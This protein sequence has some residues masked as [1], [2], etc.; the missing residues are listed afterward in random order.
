MYFSSKHINLN[1]LKN[2]RSKIKDRDKI[3]SKG[4]KGPFYM[5]TC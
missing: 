2:N 1:L 5:V 4:T 3:N